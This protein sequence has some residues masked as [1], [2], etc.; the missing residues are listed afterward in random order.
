[1]NDSLNER[2]NETPDQEIREENAKPKT[3]TKLTTDKKL[4]HTV[5][6]AL[7]V[8]L[9]YLAMFVFR[10]QVAG[11]LTFDLKDAVMCVGAFWLGPIAGVLMTALVALLEFLTVSST[12]PYGLLMNFLSS[13]SFVLA[14]SVIFRIRRT[15][16]SAIVG[17]IAAIPFMT[18]VMMVANLFITP[19]YTGM[20]TEDVANKIPT[21][22]LPFNLVKAT[23]NAAI[24]ALLFQPVRTALHR[25]KIVE[26]DLAPAPKRRA[27]LVPA[28]AA[29]IAVASCLVFF[30]VLDGE[31]S[32]LR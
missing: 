12:G 9:A 1:M 7:F 25:V 17:L 10:I 5:A 22:L 3:K 32:W 14:A 27:W 18:A 19:L 28:V 20:T 2:D 15:R 6:T 31:F 24:T 23:L 13:A 11:L 26:A 8:A 21:L 29:L 30:F 4:R 16:L